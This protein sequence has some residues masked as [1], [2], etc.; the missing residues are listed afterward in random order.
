MKEEDKIPEELGQMN[1]QEK[2]QG[3]DK[4]RTWEN[5]CTEQ[6]VRRFQQRVRKYK[7]QSRNEEYTD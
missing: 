1:T 2:V 4:Q 7:D 6:G 5:G 3:N